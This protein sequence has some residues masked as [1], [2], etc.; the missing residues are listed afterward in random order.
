MVLY[1]RAIIPGGTFFFTITTQDR[2]PILCDK[3]ARDALRRAMRG[4]ASRW[5]YRCEAIVLLPD[6]LHAVWTLPDGDSDYSRRWAWIKKEFTKAWLAAGGE[7][8][9]PSRGM[10]HEGRRGVLQ[11]GFWEH[12]IR[13]DSDLVR[14][15]DYIHYNPVKHGFARRS[16]DWPWSSFHRY[17]RSGDYPEDWGSVEPSSIGEVNSDLL[18]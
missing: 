15:L 13:D 16:R 17:V 2:I 3:R 8:L 5:F 18:E 12:A 9:P 14:H 11:P 7:E 6:H 4:C 1:R 10:R